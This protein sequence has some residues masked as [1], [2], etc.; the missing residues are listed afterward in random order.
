M[1]NKKKSNNNEIMIIDENSIKDKIYVIRGIQV[2][3]DFDL[4]CIY[5]YSTKAFN[6]QV[7]NN[8]DKF[9]EDFRFQLTR[10]EVEY[11]VRSKILTS[12]DSS[13]FKGQSG[14][15]RYLPYAF[16]EQGIYMLMTVLKGELAIRQSKALIRMFK[17]MKDYLINTNQL[18]LDSNLLE[19]SIQ[20]NKNTLD[21]NSINN[22]LTNLKNNTIMRKDLSLL[23]DFYNESTLNQEILLVNGDYFKADIAFN[24]IY[25]KATYS[26][27]IIDDYISI[28]TL[29]YLR[30]INK[31]I[32]VTIISN[33][34][35][36]L[37]RDEF[38]DFTKQYPNVNIIFIKSNNK[39]HDR[40]III[41]YD[42]E[43]MKV[44][45]LGASIKD[46]GKKIS[47]INN[48]L[49]HQ[50]YIPLIKSLLKNKILK[51]D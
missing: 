11:L 16:S 19:L 30:N 37:S 10:E 41:D 47:M 26:I 21:I 7:R 44:Y 9:D 34:K 43:K 36:N 22:E 32:F 5:G 40:Y 38:A 15:S 42:T 25:N 29:N 28:R 46:S 6:Q 23:I 50:P 8:I 4:A 33:N 3:L 12:R 1:T 48:I 17:N 39:V 45:H 20:T 51:L 24:T 14:G 31:N 35:S 49:D 2:M 27:I 18:V 13:L